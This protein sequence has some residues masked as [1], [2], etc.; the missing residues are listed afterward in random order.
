MVPGLTVG[1]PQG[2]TL[3]P[4]VSQ[5]DL[6]PTDLP[7]SVKLGEVSSKGDLETSAVTESFTRV[8]PCHNPPPTLGKAT[9]SHRSRLLGSR[10]SYDLGSE[11]T[12]VCL[13][14]FYEVPDTATIMRCTNPPDWTVIQDDI[15]CKGKYVYHDMLWNRSWRNVFINI[16]GA[17]LYHPTELVWKQCVYI[18]PRMSFCFDISLC[19]ETIDQGTLIRSVM[20]MQQV[21]NLFAASVDNLLE[22]KWF[23]GEMDYILE[24]HAHKTMIKNHN[25]TGVYLSL[26]SLSL[27]HHCYHVSFFNGRSCSCRNCKTLQSS[28]IQCKIPKHYIAGL[29]VNYGISNTKCVGDTIVYQ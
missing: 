13:P 29:V 28:G 18:N 20:T 10:G 25:A 1:L 11:V 3:P 21:N 4:G 8:P 9:L 14:S 7:L 24:I 2:P 26:M 27:S 12:Y 23:A 15:S 6:D 22:K 19:R 17:T 16:F 5:A